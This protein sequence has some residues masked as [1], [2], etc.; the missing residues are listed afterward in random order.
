MQSTVDVYCFKRAMKT[1]ESTFFLTSY[2][3]PWNSVA[4]TP[5][6]VAISRAGC[7]TDECIIWTRTGVFT[8]SK[9]KVERL[10]DFYQRHYYWTRRIQLFTRRRVVTNYLCSVISQWCFLWMTCADQIKISKA[11]MYNL[12]HPREFYM[13][14]KIWGKHAFNWSSTN[15]QDGTSGRSSLEEGGISASN[16]FININL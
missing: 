7:K 1:L 12:K 9:R 13:L 10:S 15:N 14:T 2:T 4:N 16:T 6:T 8:Y 3:F 11:F 5:I